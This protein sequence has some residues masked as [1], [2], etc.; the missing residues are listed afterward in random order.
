MNGEF[1]FEEDRLIALDTIDWMVMLTGMAACAGVSSTALPVYLLWFVLFFLLRSRQIR[2]TQEQA[3]FYS[4]IAAP[5]ALL[6]HFSTGQQ[7]IAYCLYLSLVQLVLIFKIREKK[8]AIN[9]IF[10][11]P[12]LQLLIFAHHTME[13]HFLLLFIVFLLFFVASTIRR[14][15]PHSE[16]VI[17]LKAMTLRVSLWLLVCLVPCFL[18]FPRASFT[19]FRGVAGAQLAGF[20]NEVKLGEVGNIN[21]TGRLI[22]RVTAE[23]AARWR[24]ATLN[25]Y[26]GRGW[27]STFRGMSL[28]ARGKGAKETI[29]WLPSQGEAPKGEFAGGGTNIRIEPAANDASTLLKQEII[30]EPIANRNIFGAF[31]IVGVETAVGSGS[32]IIARR[33][34]ETV[35]R[36]DRDRSR[37][38]VYTVYSR[39]K[40]TSATIL[41]TATGHVKAH[42]SKRNYILIPQL[43]G[44]MKTLA[45]E[46]ITR[47][48]ARTN[49]QKAVAIE[50][51]LTEDSGLSY[52]TNAP[53]PGNM[54]PVEHFIFEGKRG[55]CELFA[56]AMA[57][58]LRT[59]K[60]PSRIVNGFNSGDYN[61]FGGYYDVRDSDAHSWVD[62]YIPNHGWVEFDP[63]PGGN[64]RPGTGLAAFFGLSN[65]PT[66]MRFRAF[67]D[68]LDASWQRNVII[69]SREHQMTV[70]SQLVDWLNKVYWRV[71]NSALTFGRSILYLLLL[72]AFFALLWRTRAKFQPILQE[73][74]L[75]LSALRPGW[76]EFEAEKQD[77]EVGGFYG[78]MLKTLSDI[79]GLTKPSHY[80]PREYLSLVASRTNSETSTAVSYITESYYRVAYGNKKLTEE[81]SE[82]LSDLQKVLAERPSDQ[83]NS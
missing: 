28:Y 34:D 12:I 67:F 27:R 46:I 62:V 51:Y 73:L 13:L 24:G 37:K 74:L 56:S 80:T 72:F 81:E 57:L 32:H 58:L 18:I 41:A 50:K 17:N 61:Y 79:H 64:A 45:Q 19:F 23:K 47:A 55:H 59:V 49:Y 40:S 3:T 2:F 31:D 44:R 16:D 39:L 6:F 66:W 35:F 53:F 78:K 9:K 63:T 15:L 7:L 10:L 83:N 30:L 20:A 42:Y 82:K 68:A 71:R 22:M 75:R 14:Q 77:K 69:Y 43:A 52:D 48:G 60:V 29:A 25:H 4:F 1:L 33:A 70:A 5:I 21:A 11:V 76:L 36:T 65:S 26:T 54:D 38:F 8:S